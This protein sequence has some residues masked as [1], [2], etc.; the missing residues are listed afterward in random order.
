MEA[1]LRIHLRHIEGAREEDAGYDLSTIEGNLTFLPDDRVV[2]PI[3][4]QFFSAELCSVGIAGIEHL[5]LLSVLLVLVRER[6]VFDNIQ[7]ERTS[8]MAIALQRDRVDGIG[9]IAQWRKRKVLTSRQ[10]HDPI[11]R[12]AVRHVHNGIPLDP[13]RRRVQVEREHNEQG[14]KQ[15]QE[16]APVLC[17]MFHIHS[18]QSTG[19]V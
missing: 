3:L 8:L 4:Q 2:L 17:L 18:P 19:F 11:I 1:R 5:K 16:V 12:G 14:N 10:L 9:L 13:L 15:P 7:I 6:H